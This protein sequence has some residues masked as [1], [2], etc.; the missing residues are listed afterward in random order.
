VRNY[1]LAPDNHF[2]NKAN[3]RHNAWRESI[4]SIKRRVSNAAPV[5]K[6]TYCIHRDKKKT[7]RRATTVT[8]LAA[9]SK[10]VY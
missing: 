8:S 3:K 4:H 10:A 7:L 2:N 9:V 1:S 5:N 6:D